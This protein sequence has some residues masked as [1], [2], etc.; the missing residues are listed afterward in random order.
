MECNSGLALLQTKTA[1]SQKLTAVSHVDV[2][3][4]AGESSKSFQSQKTDLEIHLENEEGDE[5]A[6]DLENDGEEFD[7]DEEESENED[8]DEDEEDLKNNGEEFDED[9]EE[10]ENENEDE[11]S[12]DEQDVPKEEEAT[13]MRRISR[14]MARSLTRMRRNL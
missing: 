1:K 3:S 9:E 4:G 11:E 14:T 6:E 5:D 13:R 10:S 8:G 7:E 2:E 12:E